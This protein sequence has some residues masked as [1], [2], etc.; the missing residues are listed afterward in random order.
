[1]WRLST[2]V[3]GGPSGQT[4]IEAVFPKAAEHFPLTFGIPLGQVQSPDTIILL[5]ENGN[6]LPSSCIPLGNWESPVVVGRLTVVD[7]RPELST[8]QGAP[9]GELWTMV[10]L[11]REKA[12]ER[13]I[14][15][16]PSAGPDRLA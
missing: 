5:D 6:E 12:S 14:G 9:T 2:P 3:Y 11:P 16:W 4:T 8:P 7:P 15:R 13:R 10:A 1:M